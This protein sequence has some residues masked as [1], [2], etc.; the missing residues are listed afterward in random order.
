VSTSGRSDPD[1]ESLEH[2]P[3]L[4]SVGQQPARWR[5]ATVLIVAL[6]ALGA[7]WLKPWEPQRPADTPASADVADAIPSALPGADIAAAATGSASPP[8]P[9]P[10]QIAFAARHQHC[11]LSTTWHLLTSESTLRRPS[12]SLWAG[13]PGKATGPAD[14]ALPL[15]S[16]RVGSLQAVGICGPKTPV[17]SPAEVLRAVV[18]WQIGPDGSVREVTRPRLL[19]VALYDLGEAYFQPPA[20]EGDVWPAGRYVFEIRRLAGGESSSSRW[21]GLEFVPSGPA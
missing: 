15:I 18:L 11:R 5:L 8:G 9:T 3:A 21:L 6:V 17:V 10:D 14:P 2:T 16:V 20:G 19:D 7:L 4:Q 12:R 1:D 13:S